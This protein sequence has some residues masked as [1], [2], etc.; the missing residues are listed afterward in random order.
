MVTKLWKG[1]KNLCE[2]GFD[3]DNEQISAFRALEEINEIDKEKGRRKKVVKY[4]SSTI[5]YLRIGGQ[6]KEKEV[7]SISKF[8]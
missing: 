6:L 3:Q 4:E 8:K 5:Q 7:I 1:A 2:V